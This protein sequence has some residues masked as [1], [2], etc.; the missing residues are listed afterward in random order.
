MSMSSMFTAL[1]VLT[2]LQA[3]AP[4]ALARTAS[5]EFAKAQF[6]PLM[7]RFNAQM[8]AAATEAILQTALTQLTGKVG[9]FSRAE[10]TTACKEAAAMRLCVTPLLFE[11]ATVAL[12]I[13]VDGDGLIAGLVIA[14]VTPSE[15]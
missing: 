7:A 10:G 9:A 14:G 3:P 4:D 2:V 8:K 13:A 11:R 5:E 12:Q 6:A 15:K 1:L